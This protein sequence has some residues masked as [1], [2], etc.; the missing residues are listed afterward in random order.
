MTFDPTKPYNDLPPL[1][2]QANVETTAVLRKAIAAGRALAELKGV[3]ETI[4][5]QSIL[6]NALV[7]QEAQA[8][9]EI[10]N[11]ATTSDALFE[12]F[13]TSDK[14]IDPAT[15]EVL[16]YREALW[17]GYRLLKERGP[18]S[19]NLFIELV[20]TIKKNKAGIR[21]TPG[22][23]VMNAATGET[24]YT[25]PEGMGTLRDKL[26]NI[27]AFIH[28]EQDGM[29]PLIKLPLIHY[30]F[31]AIHP[32]T[33]GNG[34]TGR[35]I[36]ILY[37]VHE[38]LL[39]LPILSLSKPIIEHKTDYYRLIRGVTER[40]EWEPWVLYILDAV[41]RTAAFTKERIFQIRDLLAETLT[42]C[43]EHLPKKVYSKELIEILFYR[44]YTKV[45]HLVEAGIVERKTA[46]VYLSELERIGVLRKKK[47]GRENLYL[48]VRLYNLLAKPL[49]SNNTKE[50]IQMFTPPAP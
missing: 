43:K 40:N 30:Q 31:E 26:H 11:I 15:K 1:P 24:V 21:S 41:E 37:L 38:N 18:L 47:V 9:S 33:D 14:E 39:E 44:P 34:R 12:A 19:T 35:I 46:A 7:L 27:E 6:V 10:E 8:S 48:N 50:E 49:T 20:Q 25:P 22:T 17:E 29:D 2:P 13:S 45:E 23:K 5:N 3:G 32:F 16:H 28:E 36:N 4:P 42:G